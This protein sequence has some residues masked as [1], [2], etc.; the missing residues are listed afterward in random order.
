ME[1][2]GLMGKRRGRGL[3]VIDRLKWAQTEIWYQDV[4]AGDA[5]LPTGR[6]GCVGWLLECDESGRCFPNQINGLLK[7]ML[8]SICHILPAPGLCAV[9]ELLGTCSKAPHLLIPHV[10]ICPGPVCLYYNS[11]CLALL[12]SFEKMYNSITPDAASS[13]RQTGY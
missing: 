4:G 9:D 11:I 3:G 6:P 8:P 10:V 1:G 13:Y 2:S 12:I 5:C 7:G